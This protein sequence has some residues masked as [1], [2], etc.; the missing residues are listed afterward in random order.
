VGAELVI[1]QWQ[2]GKAVAVFPPAVATA[3]ALWP[4]V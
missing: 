3:T 4:K 2:D 1:I